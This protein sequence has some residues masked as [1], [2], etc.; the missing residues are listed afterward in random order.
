MCK[1]EIKGKIPYFGTEANPPSHLIIPM[2]TF[3][4]QMTWQLNLL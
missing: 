4:Y 3:M 2:H 1:E